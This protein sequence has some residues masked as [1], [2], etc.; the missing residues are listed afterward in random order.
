MH[1]CRVFDTA[2]EVRK[3]HGITNAPTSEV[4]K[5]DMFVL[6]MIVIKQKV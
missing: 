6:L 4:H 1:I 5:A 3:L 2:F